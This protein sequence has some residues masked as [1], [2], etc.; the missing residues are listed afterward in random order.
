VK[1]FLDFY[2]SL[3]IIPVRQ[4]IDSP[5]LK[6]LIFEL[7]NLCIELPSIH[8]LTVSSISDF[9]EFLNSTDRKNHKFTC[10]KSWWGRGQQYISLRKVI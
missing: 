9:I 4:N 8:R 6:K 7:E 5:N 3:N 2:N 1:A 10:F